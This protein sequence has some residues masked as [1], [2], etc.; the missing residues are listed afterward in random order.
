MM[1]IK[2]GTLLKDNTE[3]PA[4]LDS[5]EALRSAGFGDNIIAQFSQKAVN[6][7]NEKADR[8]KKNSVSFYTLLVKTSHVCGIIRNLLRSGLLARAAE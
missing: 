7:L 8:E 6:I 5:I 1:T 3:N 2:S 4:I